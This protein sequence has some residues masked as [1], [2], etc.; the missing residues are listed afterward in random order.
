MACG[1]DG[2]HTTMNTPVRLWSKAYAPSSDPDP[3]SIQVDKRLWETAM[4]DESSRRK[5]LRV[6]NN[7]SGDA[8]IA[9]IGQPVATHYDDE[10]SKEERL[11]DIFL[12]LW[13]I[14]SWCL[15]GEGEEAEVT[16]IDDEYFP[17]ATRIKLRVID[18]AIYNSDIKDEL[19]KA[20]SALGVIQEHTTLQIPVTALGGYTVEVFVSET[21]PANIVLCHGEEVALEFEEPVDQISAP[22][23]RPPT[24]IPEPLPMLPTETMIPE[25]LMNASQ[26]QGFRAFQGEGHVIGT[27][28]VN[29]PEWRRELGP[30][31]RKTP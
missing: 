20:L 28:N 5:F 26:P 14:D 12:P 4:R 6:P 25:T 9:P 8:W 16:I 21:E 7:T 17:E 18:S 11:Y 10:E 2:K 30:P 13:M 3:F 24:P 31:K 1:V 22:P 19:E 15:A 23:P 29:I 27:S